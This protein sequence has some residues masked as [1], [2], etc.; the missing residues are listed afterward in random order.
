LP[1]GPPEKPTGLVAGVF[2]DGLVNVGVAPGMARCAADDLLATTPEA[3]LLALGIATVPRP[4]AVN[5]LLETA[6]KRCGVTQ[7]Q[8]DAAAKASGG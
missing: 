6:A 7:A 8:L 4:A 2:Y 3:Q 5:T 1:P